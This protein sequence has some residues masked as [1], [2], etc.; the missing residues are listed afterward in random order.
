MAKHKVFISFHSKDIYYKELFIEKFGHLFIS[1]SVNEGDIDED[2]S[3]EYVKRLI[4]E[5]YMD[6]S[7][8][9]IV[10]IGA[11]TWCRRHVDWE[12]YGGL[13]VRV[14]GRAGLLGICIPGNPDYPG[15]TYAP[16]NTPARFVDNQK[17]G[18]ARYYDWSDDPARVERWIE[19]AFQARTEKY[20]DADNSRLQLT[21]NL[22]LK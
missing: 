7:S 8:V 20:D 18:Y 14:G 17:A 11:K 15:P 3:P 2:H 16:A 6:D 13:S 12:I 21:N 19:E 10:L 9:V 1:K 22:Q 4:N 5:G